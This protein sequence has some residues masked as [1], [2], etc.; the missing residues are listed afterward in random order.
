MFKFDRKLCVASVTLYLLIN[1]A[2]EAETS[3][4]V[5]ITPK[6]ARK[7]TQTCIN[8]NMQILHNYIKMY[9]LF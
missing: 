5:D 9:L 6:Y 4:I 7:Q 8:F 2:V 1:S 3:H